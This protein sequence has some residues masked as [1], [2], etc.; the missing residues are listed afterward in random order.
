MDFWLEFRRQ[1]PRCCSRAREAPPFTEI[2]VSRLMN[3]L[4]FL[5]GGVIDKEKERGLFMDRKGAR[6]ARSGAHGGAPEHLADAAHAQ[7]LRLL[8]EV[9]RAGPAAHALSNCRLSDS[10]KP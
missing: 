8:E 5:I 7:H 2:T 1:E 9:N 6:R 10:V 4:F 3:S